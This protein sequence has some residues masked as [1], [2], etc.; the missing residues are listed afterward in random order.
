MIYATIIKMPYLVGGK[1]KWFAMVW[2]SNNQ[3]QVRD[4]SVSLYNQDFHAWTQKQAHLLKSGQ[5]A[6]IDMENIIEEIE[7]M[8]ASERSQLQSRLKILIGHLLKWQYQ[9][10]FRSRSWKLTIEEQRLSVVEMMEDS[11]SLKGVLAERLLKAYVHGVL[12]AAKETYID[13]K[14]FPET[15]PY[16][17]EQILDATYYPDPA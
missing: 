4:M 17:I 1:R 3:L 13:K 11:P 2:Q 7:G 12:L 6:D 16:T 15:C 10:A 8:G 14:V 5:L 9:P